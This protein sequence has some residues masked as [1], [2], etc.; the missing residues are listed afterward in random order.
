VTTVVNNS[1]STKRF[2]GVRKRAIYGAFFAELITLIV[3]FTESPAFFWPQILV[4]APAA[5]VI[6]LITVAALGISLKGTFIYTDT[7]YMILTFI[8]NPV[9]GAIFCVCIDSIVRSVF[10][11][12]G[13]DFTKKGDQE[14]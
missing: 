3:M 10:N 5:G 8:V 1:D 9:L 14:K 12:K 11:F 2:C 13:F 6:E 7:F 4:C